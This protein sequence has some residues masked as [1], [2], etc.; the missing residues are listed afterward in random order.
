MAAENGR[1]ELDQQAATMPADLQQEGAIRFNPDEFPIHRLAARILLGQEQARDYRLQD[2]HTL[3][4]FQQKTQG[5][6]KLANKRWRNKGFDVQDELR[7]EWRMLYGMFVDQVIKPNLGH[8]EL[9]YQR[10]PVL[11]IH[12]PG[13]S[14]LGHKHRDEKYGRQPWEVNLWLPLTPVFGTN[15]LFVESSRGKQDWHPL[16]ALEGPGTCIRFWGSQCEH[17]TKPNDTS[18]TRVSLD[19]RAIPEHLFIDN[20]KSPISHR[21][22]GM[23]LRGQSYTD[24]VIERAWREAYHGLINNEAT[25]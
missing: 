21:G 11:R 7:D 23:H 13:D 3:P 8:G 9:V 25:E 12:P 14:A 1:L 5:R 16:V 17:F 19:F 18:V 24:T 10:E 15:S 20:Y 4:E 2:L 22:Q 6:S